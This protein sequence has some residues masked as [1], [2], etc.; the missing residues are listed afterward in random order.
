MERPIPFPIGEFLVERY[1][2]PFCVLRLVKIVFRFRKLLMPLMF[3]ETRLP[4]IIPP[5]KSK[6]ENTSKKV[7]SEEGMDI[8]ITASR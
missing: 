2:L 4:V 5:N 7:Y 6:K 3:S 8:N 1:Y